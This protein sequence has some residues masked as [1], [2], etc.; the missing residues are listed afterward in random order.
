MST[1]RFTVINCVIAEADE[2]VLSS[3]FISSLL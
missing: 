3:C 1:V 2:L